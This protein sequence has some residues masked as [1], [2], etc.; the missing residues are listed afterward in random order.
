MNPPLHDHHLIPGL[1][2]GRYLYCSQKCEPQVKEEADEEDEYHCPTARVSAWALH[3]HKSTLG[4]PSTTPGI[5]P[6]PSRR[7]IHLREQRPT[8][9][10]TPDSPSTSPSHASTAVSA[11]TATDSL[12][13]SSMAP[14]SPIS[15]YLP[16]SWASP[17]V[18]STRLPSAMKH[19]RAGSLSS[20]PHSSPQ[21]ATAPPSEQTSESDVHLEWWVASPEDSSGSLRSMSGAMRKHPSFGF[22]RPSPSRE[23]R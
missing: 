10:V 6:S 9:W 12:V 4:S 7:K 11:S 18:L 23:G 22:I 15:R 1:Q 8:C 2:Q 21:Q 16:R 19:A 14:P 3:C 17:A 5:F 13:A 20:K